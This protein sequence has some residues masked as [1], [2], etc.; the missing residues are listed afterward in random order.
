MISI[1]TEPPISHEVPSSFW[2]FLSP[3]F[4]LTILFVIKFQ[5]NPIKGFLI[6]K[7]CSC[8]CS[9][10]F[11]LS[12]PAVHVALGKASPELVKLWM[13]LVTQ[14]K[15][16]HSVVEF[17]VLF[18][19][20]HIALGVN[21]LKSSGYFIYR[22]FNIQQFYVLPTQCIYVFCVDLRT[23]SDYFPIQH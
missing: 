19:R 11:C 20:N 8:K 18:R 3:S 15:L 4:T 6:C 9:C 5:M 23:N 10:A 14:K 13:G 22:Q 17:C 21:P 12:G 7:H 1:T 16:K 2:D